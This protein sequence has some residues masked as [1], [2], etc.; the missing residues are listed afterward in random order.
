MQET[1]VF[2][3]GRPSSH[4]TVI[5][6]LWICEAGQLEDVNLRPLGQFY[7]QSRKC[8]PTVSENFWKEAVSSE[9]DSNME[10][11]ECCRSGNN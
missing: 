9:I 6:L 2:L 4:K 5:S 10:R 8:F 3:E 11:L 1:E 7:E